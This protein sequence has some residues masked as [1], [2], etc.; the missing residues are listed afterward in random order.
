MGVLLLVLANTSCYVVKHASI[1]GSHP[2]FRRL[3][4]AQQQALNCTPTHAF[5]IAKLPSGFQPDTIS[6]ESRQTLSCFGSAA[7][8]D[9]ALA[10]PT[11]VA[12]EVEPL[13]DFY[14]Q[15]MTLLHEAA[16]CGSTCK[17]CAT[18]L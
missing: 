1:Y 7:L 6:T 15:S 18:A 8:R 10:D 13:R 17:L 12:A 14:R 11:A 3:L 5:N 9:P 2:P 16:E 4:L